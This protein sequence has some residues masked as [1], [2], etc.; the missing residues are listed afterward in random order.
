MNARHVA[1]SAIYI[2]YMCAQCVHRQA[3][4]VYVHAHTHTYIHIHISQIHWPRLCLRAGSQHE[5]SRMCVG[6]VDSSS[7]LSVI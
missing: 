4:T 5:K 7:W 1:G 6:V 2:G 3:Y